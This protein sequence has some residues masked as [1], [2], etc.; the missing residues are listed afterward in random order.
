MSTATNIFSGSD[1]KLAKMVKTLADRTMGVKS[2][3]ADPKAGRQLVEL[4]KAADRAGD[5]RVARELATKDLCDIILFAAEHGHV[6]MVNG[7]ISAGVSPTFTS[8]AGLRAI[9]FA[10]MSGQSE[11]IGALVRAGEDPSYAGFFSKSVLRHAIEKKKFG[12]AATLVRLG[13]DVKPRDPLG[14]STAL[15]EAV[16]IG[17][18]KAFIRLM[19]EHGA[20]VND[21]AD[22][23]L[24]PL[25]AA[26]SAGNIGAVQELIDAGANV[27]TVA[28]LRSIEAIDA[29]KRCGG[30]SED[31]FWRRMRAKAID[32]LKTA[33]MLAAG[34]GHSEIVDA[35]LAAGAKAGMKDSEGR[36]AFDIAEANAHATV[37]RVLRGGRAGGPPETGVRD[38]LAA[39]EDGNAHR[40]RELIAA[41]I[42]INAKP[43]VRYINHG[44]GNLE[45]TGG[46]LAIVVAATGGHVDIVKQLLQAGADVNARGDATL[47]DNGQTALHAAA[48]RGHL[49]VI[50]ALIAAGAN[51]KLKEKGSRDT[52]GRTAMQI[53][54]ENKR[55]AVVAELLRAGASG[56]K[57]AGLHEA[58]QTGDEALVRRL[59]ESGVS[60]DLLATGT[61]W[62]PLMCAS[63]M[64]YTNVAKMLLDAG[65]NVD[66]ANRLGQTALT[67]AVHGAK[68]APD[69]RANKRPLRSYVKT[70]RLLLVRGADVNIDAW[71]EMTPLQMAQQSGLKS[72]AG[73]L[74]R[75][76]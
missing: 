37:L 42:D 45:P 22:D 28:R 7:L 46:R 3:T 13:A 52:P 21:A 66:L 32:P 5:G 10:A 11:V 18:N 16:K 20:D 15:I 43:V 34:N 69:V 19:V 72:L 31:K 29:E 58:A 70:V 25:M 50:Q 59:L 41:G 47:F 64:G 57:S 63:F 56:G 40:V 75:P 26:A 35:L 44:D 36:T 39:V 12:A 54:A 74:Q 55:K 24:T 1:A 68:M 2:R 9:N 30:F 27:N 48:E 65:A 17:A 53:A 62:S 60:I 71:N 61:R 33:L 14:G 73:I 76:R 8:I 67:V 4:F 23:G 6:E 38:L 51:V 49:K